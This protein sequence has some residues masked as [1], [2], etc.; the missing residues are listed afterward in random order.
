MN[1]CFSIL[2]ANFLAVHD[3]S[4]LHRA[5]AHT[6]QDASLCNTNNP[7]RQAPF[8]IPSNSNTHLQHTARTLLPPPHKHISAPLRLPMLMIQ[9]T[10]TPPPRLTRLPPLGAR[11]LPA[12]A[13]VPARHARAGLDTA[14][15]EG[16]AALV[17]RNRALPRR[18]HGPAVVARARREPRVRTPHVQ[19]VARHGLRA[20]PLEQRGQV[21]QKGGVPCVGVGF[22]EAVGLLEGEEVEHEG[23]QRG[24]LAQLL[25]QDAGVAGCE[26]AVCAV[27][28]VRG[29]VYHGVAQAFDAKAVG[30]RIG[31]Q[32]RVV[33]GFTV[34]VGRR[35]RAGV[36][37]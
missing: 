34:L 37:P 28:Q 24:R 25:V 23:A 4:K 6:D 15:A 5:D 17:A 12:P 18:Q 20:G 27:R 36:E 35:D 29:Q 16:D 26:H 2:E 10:P 13:V 1:T 9:R 22:E 7:K 8:L 3:N 31:V 32:E 21:A 33:C 11:T 30:E 19:A 14:I